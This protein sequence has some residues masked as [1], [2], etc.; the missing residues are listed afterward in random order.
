VGLGAVL[1]HGD[2]LLRQGL[3]TLEVR[4]PLVARRRPASGFTLGACLGGGDGGRTDGLIRG[5]RAE[6]QSAQQAKR[7][8]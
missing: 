3:P 6:R 7:D 4:L 8:G 5:A 1:V 2:G